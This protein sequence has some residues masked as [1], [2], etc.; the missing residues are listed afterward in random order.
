[1]AEDINV[2]VSSKSTSPQGK[3]DA[4]VVC[5]DIVMAVDG[6]VIWMNVFRP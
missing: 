3:F 4:N 6:F 2:N 1:M 5:A